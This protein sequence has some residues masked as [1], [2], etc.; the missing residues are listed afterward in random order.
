MCVCACVP[1]GVCA[2]S[3]LLRLPCA[4]N[5]RGHRLPRN[6]T[7]AAREPLAAAA[8]MRTQIPPTHPS[9]H[10]SHPHHTHHAN[11]DASTHAGCSSPSS[12]DDGRERRAGGPAQRAG[13]HIA[14]R[15]QGEVCAGVR[16]LLPR[17]WI[18]RLAS[19][20][21]GSWAL[22]PIG[23][24]LLVTLTASLSSSIA[25]ACR[26]RRCPARARTR[27]TGGSSS[28]TSCFCCG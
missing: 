19:V 28:G 22:Q 14:C 9:S 5:P 15:A 13:P 1:V 10:T 8:G 21:E 4:G 16:V 12:R 6:A 20:L 25:Y 2:T 27:P 23:G 7:A 24:H 3:R 18:G 26:C 17:E 11:A